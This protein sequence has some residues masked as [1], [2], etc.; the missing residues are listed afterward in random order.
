[1]LSLRTWGGTA[2]NC[3]SF[4]EEAAASAS[5]VGE[6][7]APCGRNVVYVLDQ[8]RPDYVTRFVPGAAGERREVIVWASGCVV[9]GFGRGVSSDLG[10]VGV[11]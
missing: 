5:W 2:E 8:R 6:D 9:C 1:M 4:A 7:L 10:S 11:S 3:P